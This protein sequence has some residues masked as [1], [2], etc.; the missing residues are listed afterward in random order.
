MRKLVLLTTFV[1]GLV[2]MAKS[3][4]VQVES[5]NPTSMAKFKWE[6]TTHDFAKIEQGKPVAHEFVFTNAGTTPLVISN[7]RGSCGCTVT[8]YTKEPIAPGKTGMVK[9]TFNAAAI[10]AFN[11]SI[12][13]TANVEGANETLFIKGEVVKENL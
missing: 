1:F 12:R 6:A 5:G 13:V 10:G 2:F 4:A 9:A 8:D 7:V 11:K 3:Q